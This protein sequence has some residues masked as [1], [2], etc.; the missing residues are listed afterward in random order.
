MNARIDF[1]DEREIREQGRVLVLAPLDRLQ[2]HTV[3]Q[4]VTYSK[5]YNLC[6]E[7]AES[8]LYTG[9]TCTMSQSGDMSRSLDTSFTVLST[10]YLTWSGSGSGSESGVR[11][12]VLLAYLFLGGEP[13]D[14]EPD[15]A[16][17]HVLL[18]PQGPQHV[19]RLEGGGGAG[20]PGG[21]GHVLQG[22]QQGLALGEEGSSRRNRQ[23][24][25]QID[26][27]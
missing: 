8:E 15:G 20:G 21:Q 24:I 23:V 19:A 1:N 11:V 10:V 5:N 13:A 18:G 7:P 17:G 27:S 3:L 26:R 25:S 14:A 12:R 9:S 2:V 16:V 4:Q 6:T 22:Y